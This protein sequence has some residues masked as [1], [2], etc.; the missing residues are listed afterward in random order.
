MEYGIDLEPALHIKA[1]ALDEVRRVTPGSRLRH[2]YRWYSAKFAT[3]LHTVHQLPFTD[4]FTAYFED[5]FEQLDSEDLEAERQL[6]IET[7][8][9]RQARIEALEA[10]E[11][12]E[13]DF[14]DFADAEA[15][16]LENTAVPAQA[17]VRPIAHPHKEAPEAEMPEPERGIPPDVTVK[18]VE[19]GFFDD[20][21]DKLDNQ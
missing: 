7:A 2:V 13:R 16:R 11:S 6:I 20:L 10:E 4:I 12:S 15:K 19:E 18:F 5:Q 3:P 9:Q 17:P 21:M 8:G 1:I 14:A